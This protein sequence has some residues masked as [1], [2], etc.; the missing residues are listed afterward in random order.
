MPG[1]GDT[2]LHIAAYNRDKKLIL[3]LLY[4]GADHTIKNHQGKL[5]YDMTKNA[6]RK[7]IL[8]NNASINEALYN[9]LKEQGMKIHPT[10]VSRQYTGTGKK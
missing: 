3:Q 9:Y 10:V 1:D 5:P 8:K 7:K 4:N 6:S 2:A